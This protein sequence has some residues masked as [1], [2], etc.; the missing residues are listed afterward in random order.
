MNLISLSLSIYIWQSPLGSILY[1]LSTGS[2]GWVSGNTLVL[3]D[4]NF[5]WVNKEI[6]LAYGFYGNWCYDSEPG[7]ILIPV[8]TG[9]LK[10]LP[11]FK[12][13]QP[14]PVQPLASKPPCEFVSQFR[15]GITIPSLILGFD[16]IH[17]FVVVAVY[18]LYSTLASLG[19]FFMVNIWL[20]LSVNKRKII[21][22][23]GLEIFFFQMASSVSEIGRGLNV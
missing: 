22:C 9:L 7:Q 13:L 14:P 6:S 10:W 12:L 11:I 17:L 16:F 1:V 20:V 3:L 5:A 15:S 2:G 8:A 21:C 23:G 18:F 4:F 19:F